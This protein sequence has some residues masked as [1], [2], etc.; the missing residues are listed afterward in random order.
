M[1]RRGRRRT[2]A[3]P[4][5][6]SGGRPRSRAST[7]GKPRISIASLERRRGEGQRA[8][9]LGALVAGPVALAAVRAPGARVEAGRLDAAVRDRLLAARSPTS[10][11][12]PAAA[13]TPARRPSARGAA[14]WCVAG[15]TWSCIHTRSRGS[16]MIPVSMPF[17]CW[18][19]QRRHSCRK[20]IAG[21]GA[22]SCGKACDH[23]PIEALARAGQALDQPRDRVAVAVGPAADRVHG[24]V[25]RLVVLAHRALAPVGVAALVGEP[26]LDERRRVLDALAA[27][28]RASRRRRRPGRAAA[29]CR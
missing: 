24:H 5:A 6:R 21:P 18:S 22:P 27:T 13:A 19:N 17:R 12:A 15:A 9:V 1:R 3:P 16:S 20:P 4:P 23:G 10:T 7:S 26:R 28:C 14:A 2:A 11:P 25:D 8:L 29:R